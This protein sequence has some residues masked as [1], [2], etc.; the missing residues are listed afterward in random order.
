MFIDY[1][2]RDNLEYPNQQKYGTI[3]NG[4]GEYPLN[5]NSV[6]LTGEAEDEDIV[7]TYRKL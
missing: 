2:I 1:Q 7:Y 5:G 4:A 3:A 6:L